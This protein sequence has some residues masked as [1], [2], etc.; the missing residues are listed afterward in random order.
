V[1]RTITDTLITTKRADL[2]R[3]A[4][5]DARREGYLDKD[6]EARLRRELVRYSHTVD[7]EGAKHHSTNREQ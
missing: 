1:E 7:R 3:Q 4:V 2:A 5:A 6:Q